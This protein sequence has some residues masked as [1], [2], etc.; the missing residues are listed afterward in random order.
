M[1]EA[2]LGAH[3]ERTRIYHNFASQL[4]PRVGFFNRLGRLRDRG[5]HYWTDG[6]LSER[7]TSHNPSRI[8]GPSIHHDR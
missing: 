1:V 8:H 4:P 5:S 3:D 6:T 2:N 7:V